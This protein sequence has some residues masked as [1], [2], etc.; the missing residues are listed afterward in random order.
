MKVRQG[1]DTANECNMNDQF[2][3][4]KLKDLYLTNSKQYSH[5]YL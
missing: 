4:K 1:T 2:N 5:N 3:Q